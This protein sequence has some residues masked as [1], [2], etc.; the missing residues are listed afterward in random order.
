[1]DLRM[2]NSEIQVSLLAYISSFDQ[3][4]AYWCVLISCF[5]T[6]LGDGT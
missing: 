2:R 4:A 6:I 1:M 3:V 5:C